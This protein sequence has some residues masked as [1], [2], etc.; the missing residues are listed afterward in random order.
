MHP[1]I[2][3]CAG[4][5]WEFTCQNFVDVLRG[6]GAITEAWVQTFGD[7]GLKGGS[8]D[9]GVVTCQ[10]RVTIHDWDTMKD[11]WMIHVKSCFPAWARWGQLDI[12]ICTREY[13]RFDKSRFFAP[14]IH[15][16]T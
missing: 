8:D 4:Y 10:L 3:I 11:W 12:V 2:E 6:M 13:L 15:I 16:D 7:S 9:P 14:D 5:Q 1:V